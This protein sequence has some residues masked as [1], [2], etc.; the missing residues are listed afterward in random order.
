MQECALLICSYHCAVPLGGLRRA[1]PFW[2]TEC[3]LQAYDQ[4]IPKGEVPSVRFKEA[5][6]EAV[7]FRVTSKEG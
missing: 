1:S 3:N 2:G 6:V 5:P 4:Q 7:L